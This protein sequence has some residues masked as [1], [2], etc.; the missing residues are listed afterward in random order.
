MRAVNLSMNVVFALP[1]RRA[2]NE[3][4]SIDAPILIYMVKATIA[5]LI[6]LWISMKLNLPD[7]RTAIFTVFIVMQPQSGLVFSKSY[8]R[9]VGTIVGVG[10]SLLMMGFFAQDPIWFIGFF[11]LWIGLCTAAGFKYR[12]FQSYGFVLAGYT[13]CIVALPVI[14]TPLEVFDIAV[15]RFSEVVVGIMCATII[16]DI[17]FP[18]HLSESLLTAERER[19]GNILS[20]LAEPEAV[21]SAF[22]ETNPSVSRFSSGVVGLNAVRINSAYESG[23]DQKERQHYS[24]LNHEYMNLSTT[25]HSLKS[26][27][28]AIKEEEQ[29]LLQALE[30]LYAPIASALQTRPNTV[31]DPEDLNRV[32]GELIEAK[33]CVQERYEAEQKR[34][35]DDD[36]YTSAAY[37]IIRL[38]NELNNHCVTYLSLLKHRQSGAASKELSRFVRFSTH[39]DNVLVALAALRGSGVLLLSMMFWIWTAWPYATLTIT[40]AVVIGLLLGTLPSPIDGVKDFFKGSVLALGFAGVYDFFIIPAYTSDILTLG[41]LIAPVLAFVGWMTTRPKLAI[42]SFGFVFMFMSQCALDPMY[43]IDPTKYLESSL[44]ALI[45][46]I[47][48]GMAYLLV[49]FWSCSLTQ[50]RVAKI[51]RRQIVRVCEGELTIERSALESTGRDLVQQFSTQG[52]LNMRSS[53]LVFEW[54]LATLEIGRSILTI[55]RSLKRISPQFHSHSLAMALESIKDFFEEPSD[56]GRAGLLEELNETINSLRSGSYPT[57]RGQ[58]K[59]Y[60]ILI[61]EFALIRTIVLNSTTFPLIKEDTCH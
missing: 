10:M 58:L 47:F 26:I 41:I 27:I 56:S 23:S 57:E 35:G 3:W 39:T 24:H 43:K 50:K 42:F 14:E 32:I 16:S 17:I 6:A 51:L 22:D 25:F 4:L 1:W 33:T 30:H 20:T 2:L 29:P 36:T 13:L 46:V 55:R 52:R 31:V 34:Y 18:R 48:G 7:P 5:G 49:N 59:R 19:F 21:F 9:V 8:Y 44:A 12:N 38:L 15:S 54:L 28:A 60:E 40:M 37:L 53:R 11:A 61:V 45:G